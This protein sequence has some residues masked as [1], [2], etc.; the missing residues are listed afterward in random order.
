LIAY[1]KN[2]KGIG[3][4][5]V[6]GF[7]AFLVI[8]APY[9]PIPSPWKH[10]TSF[11]DVFNPPSSEHLLGTDD[12]GRDLLSAVIFGT[13]TSLM[14]GFF[15]AVISF[16]IGT[17][18]GLLAGYRGGILDPLLMR[19]TDSFMSIPTLALMIILA[20][21]LGASTWNVIV[22]IAVVSWP[23]TARLVRSETL[24]LKELPF[25]ERTRAI[26]AGDSHILT[27]HILPNVLPV[28]FSSGILQIA[29][30][31]FVE[32][33]LSFLGL[34]DPTSLSWGMILHNAFI[35]QAVSL[36]VWWY[37]LPPGFCI[38]AVVVGFYLVS[39]ATDEILNPRLRERR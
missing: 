25:V 30:A 9:L 26:G 39:S 23:S 27:K 8:A 33:V 32:S 34:T 3:G 17:C 24:R 15:A 22:V 10:G 2:T 19:A 16:G 37:W 13:R 6:I 18:V 21:L 7:F 28:V 29:L 4:A 12:L 35:S 5:V 38:V 11:E 1:G 31:I 20:A 14:I 36:G